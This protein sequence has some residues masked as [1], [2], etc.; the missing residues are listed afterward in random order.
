MSEPN[1]AVDAADTPTATQTSS[2]P[3]DTAAPEPKQ[4]APAPEAK[5]DPKGRTYSWEDAMKL[6]DEAAANRKALADLKEQYEKDKVESETR[7][8]NK[9]VKATLEAAALKAGVTDEK[10]AKALKAL[11]S[12]VRDQ[13]EFDEDGDPTNLTDLLNGIIEE[14]DYLVD[15]PDSRPKPSGDANP[16]RGKANTKV[17]YLEDLDALDPT[18]FAKLTDAQVDEIVARGHRS[19][20]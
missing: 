1:P 14:N 19:N 16:S 17:M 5:D 20:K 8:Q 7:A 10:K 3:A 2:A 13:V 15:K 11:F 6:R 12:E 18:A 4:T 9:V